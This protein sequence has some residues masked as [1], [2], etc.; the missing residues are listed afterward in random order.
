MDLNRLK[1]IV[2]KEVGYDIA[3]KSRIREIVYYR[4]VF[5]KI[6]REE[7]RGLTTDVIGKALNR[8]HSTVIHG[9]KK[10]DHEL[11]Y[12]KGINNLYIAIK[13][14]VNAELHNDDAA[15]LTDIQYDNF[16]TSLKEG[17]EKQILELTYQIKALSKES[18][19]PQNRLVEDIKNLSDS[20]IAEFRSTRLK[21]YLNM[22]KS[23]VKPKVIYEVAGSRLER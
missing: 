15:E 21:P 12:N 9:L 3:I 19:K 16:I 22:L 11:K 4:Y 1:Q 8:D 13:A 2:D 23:R 7:L 20:D 18:T 5:F 14:R 10:I 6:A 17:Y